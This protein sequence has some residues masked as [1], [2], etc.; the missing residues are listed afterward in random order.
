MAKI[1]KISIFILATFFLEKSNAQNYFTTS[2][3]ILKGEIKNFDKNDPNQGAFEIIFN[4]YINLSTITYTVPIDT[5]GLFNLKLKLFHPQSFVIIYLNKQTEILVTPGDTIEA[6]FD[7]KSFPKNTS[8]KGKYLSIYNQILK[9]KNAGYNI[10]YNNYKKIEAGI[11]NLEAFQFKNLCDSLFKTQIDFDSKFIDSLNCGQL[12]ASFIR[13]S[14]KLSYYKDFFIYSQHVYWSFKRTKP[15]DMTYI[16]LLDTFQI[17]PEYLSAKYFYD[18]INWSSMYLR[19]YADM[20]ATSIENK[21]MKDGSF[22]FSNEM[23]FKIRFK[24][25]SDLIN[26]FKSSLLKDLFITQF[27]NQTI[28]QEPSIINDSIYTLIK[29]PFVRNNFREA[30]TKK[31]SNINKFK[32]TFID[33]QKIAPFDSLIK[34]YPNKVLYVDFWATWCSSCYNAIKK[35]STLQYEINSKDIVFIY[36]CCRSE[37]ENWNKALKKMNSKGEH[38]YLNNSQFINLSKYINIQSFPHY[39]IISRDGKIIDT[40]SSRPGSDEILVKLK[41]LINNTG[42]FTKIIR[43]EK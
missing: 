11:N 43:D 42:T 18:L 17:K 34:L 24:I 30:I 6:E 27:I 20:L 29:D 3:I 15:I 12:L 31:I 13:G 8:F 35:S 9:Y 39:I 37:K 4:D 19:T 7:A 21:Q 1:I 16:S 28:K 14:S 10:G 41:N 22:I 2:D 36:A 26:N 33:A 38:I 5:N 23:Y 32:N 40:D 25:Y